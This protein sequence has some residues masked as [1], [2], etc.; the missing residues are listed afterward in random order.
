MSQLESSFGHILP[1]SQASFAD[2]VAGK[3][4]TELQSVMVPHPEDT[5]PR[6]CDQSCP[7][8]K[9]CKMGCS[10]VCFQPASPPPSGV[11]TS[12]T[13]W[14]RVDQ[15]R[16]HLALTYL[17]SHPGPT[18]TPCKSASKQKGKSNSLLVSL[19]RNWENG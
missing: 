18:N 6:V 14:F 1:K 3:V 4:R 5:L 13:V 11:H 12:G 7:S 8:L 15:G 17:D 16:P 9:Q 19:G 10:V 2:G